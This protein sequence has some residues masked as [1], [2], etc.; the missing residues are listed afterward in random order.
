MVCLRCGGARFKNLR[1]GVSRAREEL[2]VLTGELVAEVTA[3]AGEDPARN[4]RVVIGTEA[5]LHRLARADSVAFLDFDQELLAPR[6][7]SV[8]QA[9]GFLARAAR[10][11]E[12]GNSR[13]GRVLV[14]TRSPDH[15]VIMA[16]R[17]ADPGRLAASEAPLRD[18]LGFPPSVA[19]AVLSGAVAPE[20]VDA[21]GR[22]A[23]VT[24]QGPV[25]GAWRLVAPD[26]TTLCDALAATPRPGGRLRVEVDP[27]RI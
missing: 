16:A 6:Y 2:E 14:Q 3:A 23:G 12:R 17:L 9:L 21:F 18:A 5:A 7:R 8:E 19:M 26:H 13:D 10:L 27:L 1:L 15:P 24:V 25:D 22:P 4:S 11:V 20:F